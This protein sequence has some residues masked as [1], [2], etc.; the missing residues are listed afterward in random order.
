MKKIRTPA[1]V[2]IVVV[3]LLVYSVATI[4]ANSLAVTLNLHRVSRWVE[5]L[6]LTHGFLGLLTTFLVFR[7]DKRAPWAFAVW[8]LFI[9]SGWFLVPLEMLK[10]S[11]FGIASTAYL[12]FLGYRQ[13][14]AHTV[15]GQE[16]RR[17]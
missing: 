9:L 3:V 17:C 15:S 4:G 11:V 2:A 8:S 6:F 13:I 5:G 10:Y 12:A 16:R 1:P 7:R 14:R